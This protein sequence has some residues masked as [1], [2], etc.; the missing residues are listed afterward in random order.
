MRSCR[1]PAAWTAGEV[2]TVLHHV[3]VQ[4]IVESNQRH[5]LVVRHVGLDDGPRGVGRQPALGVVDRLVE[6]HRSPGS[7][8][9]EA[10]E[11]IGNAGGVGQQREERRVGRHHELVRG[12][13]PQ[14]EPGNAERAV[15]VIELQ[16]PS[17]EA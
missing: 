15:L 2:K 11:V 3:A 12:R 14:A 5:A 16:V 4:E 17:V 8:F 9:G 13:A 6:A 10:P 7:F 1:K